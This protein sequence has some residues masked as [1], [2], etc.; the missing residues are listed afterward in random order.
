M[1]SEGENTIK[2]GIKVKD[3][4]ANLEPELRREMD[5]IDFNLVFSMARDYP[6]PDLI[7]SAAKLFLMS[8]GQYHDKEKTG[9]TA[10]M[11]NRFFRKV[12]LPEQGQ[13]IETILV[14]VQT[15]F[16]VVRDLW[17][18]L[19]SLEDESANYFIRQSPASDY[20]F[21]QNLPNRLANLVV[22]LNTCLN[23]T[24]LQ[25]QF[26]AKGQTGY[27]A[28]TFQD[29]QTK[30]CG[31]WMSVQGDRFNERSFHELQISK[32]K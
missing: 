12:L 30:M 9:I 15:D 8:A 24:K 26:M 28:E 20:W 13:G 21:P 2:P 31:L 18:N 29:P 16:P 25:G 22:N 5:P 6:D 1:F 4:L 11:L 3:L 17:S 27:V 7:R 23:A 32:T 10:V 19:S 14:A